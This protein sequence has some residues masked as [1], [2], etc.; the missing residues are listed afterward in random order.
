MPKICLILH[1]MKREQLLD[2]FCENKKVDIDLPLDPIA[3][4]EILQDKRHHADTFA[5]EQDRVLHRNWN[6]GDH[7]E[8]PAREPLPLR[9]DGLRG[10]GSCSTVHRRVDV[11]TQDFYA[12]KQQNSSDAKEHLKKGNRSSKMSSTS[13]HCTICQVLR[14]GSHLRSSTQACSDSRCQEA[15]DPL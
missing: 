8:I 11:C 15:L 13:A 1:A 2:Y 9:F 10:A 14:A 4:E 12:V 3:A 5:A 6:E 7:I